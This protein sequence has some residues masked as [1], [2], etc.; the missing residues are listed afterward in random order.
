[1]SEQGARELAEGLFIWGEWFWKEERSILL[2]ELSQLLPKWGL[3]AG[4]RWARSFLPLPSPFLVW[5][6]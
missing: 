1:M 5:G 4:P 6:Q 3:W 2:G